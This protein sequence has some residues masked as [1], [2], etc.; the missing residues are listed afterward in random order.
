MTSAAPSRL[1]RDVIDP[2]RQCGHGL[3]RVGGVESVT[4][5]GFA[6]TPEP[7]SHA[8]LHQSRRVR[9]PAL[10]RP[11]RRRLRPR[12]RSPPPTSRR[13]QVRSCRLRIGRPSVEGLRVTSPYRWRSGTVAPGRANCVAGQHSNSSTRPAVSCRPIGWKHPRHHAGII[14]TGCREPA[15]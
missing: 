10:R 15:S 14:D 9:C 6:A 12:R 1:G 7:W 3:I 5:A 2:P 4:R 11:E 13:A 8:P